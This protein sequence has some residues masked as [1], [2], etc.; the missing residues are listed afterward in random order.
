MK[1]FFRLTAMC[2]M[3]LF[4]NGASAQID[5][6]GLL[7]GMLGGSSSSSSNSSG[8]S[9]NDLISGL[10]S[11][12]SSKKQASEKSIVGTWVYAEPAIVLK[13]DN[14]LSNVAAKVAAGKIE[15]KLAGVLSKYGIKEGM[16]SITFNEDG[17]FTENIG[18]KTIK[19]KWTVKDS[20]LNL[21]FGTLKPKTIP[22]TTQL[23]GSQLLFVTDASKL[24]DF[25]KNISSKSSNSNIKTITKLMDNVTGMQ[26]GLTMKKK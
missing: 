2:F 13:S 21:T 6:G 5:L 17:T 8:S 23:E 9:T 3:L 20:K 22:I 25:V 24:L 18:K 7:G 10:T 16:L 14:I 4:V 15:D 12:F 19:G 26:A 1:K 11:I